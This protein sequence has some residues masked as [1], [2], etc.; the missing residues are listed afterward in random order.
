MTDRL[1]NSEQERAYN[2]LMLELGELELRLEHDR[3]K[4]ALIPPDWRRIERDV[5]VRP[6]KTKLTAAFDADLVKWFRGMGHGYQ[7]QMNAVLRTF[8]LAV[9]SKEILSRGDRDS[10]GD[11]IW[12]LPAKKEK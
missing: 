10:K 4:R 1:R 7:A 8:M 5:P 3:L 9:I 11:E 12:G 6:R 2:K